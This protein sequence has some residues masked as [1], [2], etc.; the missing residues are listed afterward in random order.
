MLTADE[1]RRLRLLLKD[2]GT[3]P[4]FSDAALEDFAA[5]EGGSLK[6][7][8]ALAL[9]TIAANDLA[10]TLQY[11]KTVGLETNGEP[12]TKAVLMIADRWR[13]QAQAARENAVEDEI[14]AE[15]SLVCQ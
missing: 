1:K 3:S 11:I 7:V 8:A 13:A 2:Q 5:L 15:V 9:E 6:E 12:P 10:R 4:V 14:F